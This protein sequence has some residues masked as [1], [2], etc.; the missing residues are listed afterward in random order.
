MDVGRQLPRGAYRSVIQ[1]PKDM[2]WEPAD[3][4]TNDMQAPAPMT[5]AAFKFTLGPG[6]FGTVCLREIFKSDGHLLA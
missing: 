5:A 6:S 1:I 3:E 2:S 4:S